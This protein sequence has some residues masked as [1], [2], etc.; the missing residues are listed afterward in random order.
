MANALEYRTRENTEA[1]ELKDHEARK[2][3]K[4]KPYANTNMK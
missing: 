3:R 2:D 1:K 4:R